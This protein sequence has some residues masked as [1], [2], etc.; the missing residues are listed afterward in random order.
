M[1]P[2]DWLAV[3]FEAHRTQLRAV[4]YRM[5]G[6]LSEAD[7]AVQEAWLRL[8]RTD[9]N[10]VENIGGWLTT[11]VARVSLNMLRSRRARPEE[12]MGAHIP[13]PIASQDAEQEAMLG[14]S[15]GLALLVVLGT[16][17]PAEQLAFVLHDVFAVPFDEIGAIAGR[18]PTAARQLASRARR[19]VRA[20]AS[21][22]G[23]LDVEGRQKAADAFLA[24]ARGGD[25]EALLGVL[26]ASCPQ[27][28]STACV[29][30]RRRWSAARPARMP[31]RVR[32]HERA[33]VRYA[34]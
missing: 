15:V 19:R 31:G 34:P 23:G 32:D 29:Q 26:L 20:A 16:L 8:S 10:G 22:R 21:N 18:S 7:D 4:A 11:I 13:E 1:D 3:R 6:S 25:F 9:T 24:A 33:D 2:K 27:R 17:D 14:D 30:A 12:P 28:H 5:L